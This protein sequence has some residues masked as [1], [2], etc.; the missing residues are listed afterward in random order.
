MHALVRKS[1]FSKAQ[2][3]RETGSCSAAKY[4]KILQYFNIYMNYRD[5][6]HLFN[7]N[8]ATSVLDGELMDGLYDRLLADR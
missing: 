4:G 7:T 3:L 6:L 5:V 2:Q 8:V 1:S